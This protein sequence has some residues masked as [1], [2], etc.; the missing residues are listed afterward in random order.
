MTTSANP[1]VEGV[2]L[3]SLLKIFAISFVSCWKFKHP[4]R[5]LERSYVQ[6]VPLVHTMEDVVKRL[7]KQNK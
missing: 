5:L 3:G 4:R 7:S 1:V 2:P 6:T